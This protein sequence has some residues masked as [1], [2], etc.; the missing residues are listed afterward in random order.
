MSYNITY[1]PELKKKYPAVRTN[2]N[3]PL[4][5]ALILLV[6]FVA[7]YVFSRSGIMRYFI[8]GNPEITAEAFS[9]MV[10]RVGQGETVGNAV[11]DFCREIIHNAN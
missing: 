9:V 6:G 1:N 8:P 2:R 3:K 7:V 4:Y 11:V 5:M 10:E